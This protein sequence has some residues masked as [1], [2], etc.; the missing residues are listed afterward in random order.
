M[1]N[2]VAIS[3]D[4]LARLRKRVEQNEAYVEKLSK[5]YY[6]GLAESEAAKNKGPEIKAEENEE[7]ENSYNSMYD[8]E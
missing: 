4:A 8:F 2:R 7:L 3:D 5:Q 1:H 6:D